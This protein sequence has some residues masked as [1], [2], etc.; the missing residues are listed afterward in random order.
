MAAPE[1]IIRLHAEEMNAS[2][3]YCR[4]TAGQRPEECYTI[5][6]STP[7]AHFL[8]PAR[9]SGTARLP[10]M[11]R[12]FLALTGGGHSRTVEAPA[13]VRLAMTDRHACRPR[14]HPHTAAV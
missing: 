2:M 1:L 14:T 5:V 9:P 12:T 6:Q 10:A 7:A 3:Q 11:T 8:Y 4:C 13:G